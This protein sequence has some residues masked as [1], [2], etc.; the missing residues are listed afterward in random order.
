M[1][2]SR[3]LQ[4]TRAEVATTL[5]PLINGGAV[6]GNI[7]WLLLRGTAASKTTTLHPSSSPPTP[8]S[9][10]RLLTSAISSS[11]VHLSTSDVHCSANYPCA[12]HRQ[13]R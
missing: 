8:S 5:Q 11:H 12:S 9:L 2:L 3:G 7:A 6:D 10:S 13:R 1:Q 4:R